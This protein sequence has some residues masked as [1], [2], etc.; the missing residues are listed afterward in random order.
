MPFPVVEGLSTDFESTNVTAHS[1]TYPSGV[2]EDDLIVLLLSLNSNG[3]TLTWPTGYTVLDD[4][5]SGLSIR[6]GIAY[7]WADGTET[8]VD[9]VAGTLATESASICARIS[10]VDRNINPQI[11]TNVNVGSSGVLSI[12]PPNLAA[13]P[14]TLK[15]YLWLA[16][17]GSDSQEVVTGPSNMTGTFATVNGLDSADSTAAMDTHSVRALSFDP[18]AFTWLS[19]ESAVCWTLCIHPVPSNIPLSKMTGNVVM[20]GNMNWVK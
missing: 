3:G 6:V 9:T 14:A 7:R 5:N 1:F 16:A 19:L 13:S 10:G 11:S 17:F 12:N 8:G 20:T 4:Q 2:A 15:D 18:T